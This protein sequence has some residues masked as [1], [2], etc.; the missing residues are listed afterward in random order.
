MN[1]L[2]GS[3]HEAFATKAILKKARVQSDHH[4]LEGGF[5]HMPTPEEAILWSISTGCTETSLRVGS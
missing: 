5:S 3:E 2:Q 1:S 4:N